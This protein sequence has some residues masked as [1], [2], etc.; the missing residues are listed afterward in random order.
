MPDIDIAYA[1]VL[2]DAQHYYDGYIADMEQEEARCEP[3]AE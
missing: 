1:D 2:R 3:I